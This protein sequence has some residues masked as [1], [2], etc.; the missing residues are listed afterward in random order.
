MNALF[1]RFRIG[2]RIY[3]GFAL[4]LSLL[5][6]VGG[7]GVYELSETKDHF[8]E[9]GATST[10]TGRVL[11]I[12]LNFAELRRSVLLH[13]ND[14]GAA[15]AEY[16]EHELGLIATDLEHVLS[17][18]QDPASHTR[19]K[20]MLQLSKEYGEGF[21]KVKQ[22]RSTRESLVARKLRPAGEKLV[23]NLSTLIAGATA[24]G[25]LE[26]AGLAGVAQEHFMYA[27]LS[28]TQFLSAPDTALVEAVAKRIQAFKPAAE[29]LAAWLDDPRR[30]AMVNE[31]QQVSDVYLET[32]G[33]MAGTALEMN[34]LAFVS[35]PEL[36]AEFDGLAKETVR[37]WTTNLEDTEQETLSRVDMTIRG[38]IALSGLSLVLGIAL[39]WLIARSIVTPVKKMTDTMTRLAGGDR[40]VDVEGR[41]FADEVGEMARAVQIFKDN[42]IRTEALQEQQQLQEQRQV[43][44]RRQAMLDLADDFENHVNGVV[45][46]VATSSGDMTATATTMSAAASQATQ[47]ANAVAN[48]ADHASSN[49]QTVAAAAE[50]LAASI[51][52][53]GRQV[54]QSSRTI[55]H[56]VEKARRTNEIVGSLSEAA[57]KIGEVVGLINTIA[58]QTNLLALNA[59]IEAA[60]AG[61]AGKGFAVVAS[62]VKNLANQTA[63][64]TDDI[65]MQIAAVQAATGQAVEAI[66]D[67]LHTIDEVSSTSAAIAASVEQQQSATGEIARNVEQAAAGTSEVAANI[68]GVTAASDASRAT[69][70]QVLRES[71]E[72]TRQSGVLRKAVDEFITK[73]RAA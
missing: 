29:R 1:S 49:V 31:A 54:D 42:A 9:Y 52:E 25:E 66:Q 16:A 63:K 64:A 4:V 51:S 61:D 15:S 28:A 45:N 22:A 40:T 62:E 32:F 14:G 27:R 68:A 48:A 57:Q 67:I 38:S 36:A 58:G 73:V 37:T 6:I 26:L 34:R 41:S 18:T 23:S 72:L 21:A 50:E 30:L 69:A 17:V 7:Y 55:Q 70:E 56:A 5:G 13:I 20:R 47:Q 35:M 3:F 43:Q 39:A 44:E 12:S 53:I 10:D 60:R 59:T 19:L 24:E 46:H 11:T 65:S 71:S 33:E 2:F 8:E